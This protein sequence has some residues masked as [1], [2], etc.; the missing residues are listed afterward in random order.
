M[1]NEEHPT[2]PIENT[3]EKLPVYISFVRYDTGEAY[4]VFSITYSETE[5]RKQFKEDLVTVAKA[6]PDDVTVLHLCSYELPQA[7]I[8]KIDEIRKSND[9]GYENVEFL[10]PIL[11]DDATRKELDSEDGLS[12]LDSLVELYMKQENIEDEDECYEI[13]TNLDEEQFAEL[14]KKWVEAR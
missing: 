14:I 11:W 10:E 12:I 7:T 3:E 1:D 5:A 4:D 8:A 9:D 2:E 6:M 13:M